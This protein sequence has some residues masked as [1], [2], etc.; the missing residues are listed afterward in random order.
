VPKGLHD[1]S[2]VFSAPLAG[3]NVPLPFF[4]DANAA[5]WQQAIGYEIAGILGMLML[6]VAIYA[7]VWLIRRPGARRSDAAAKP[8]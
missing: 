1:L 6:G 7:V 8:I 3:Y 5:L 4:S 2:T